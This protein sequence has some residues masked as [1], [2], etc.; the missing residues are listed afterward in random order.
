MRFLAV[1]LSA[2]ILLMAGKASA[3]ANSARELW[4]L[5]NIANIDTLES[6]FSQCVQLPK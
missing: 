4:S 3:V 2:V 1:L 6:S 5:F